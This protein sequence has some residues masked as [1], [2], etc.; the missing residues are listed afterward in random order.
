M[1]LEYHDTIVPSHKYANIGNDTAEWDD[2]WF[3][4]TVHARRFVGDELEISGSIT[5]TDL[6]A[7]NIIANVSIVGPNVT[8]GVDPGH[9]HSIYLKADGTTPLT[10]DWTTGAHSIIGSDHWYMRADDKKMFFGGS[11]EGSIFFD[12][13]ALRLENPAGVLLCQDEGTV[14]VGEVS[15]FNKLTVTSF[16]NALLGASKYALKLKMSHG[17]AGGSTPYPYVLFGIYSTTETDA[18]FGG[19]V[20]T[21][22]GQRNNV[23]HAGTGT[24][25]LALANT[26]IIRIMPTGGNITTARVLTLSAE[27][28]SSVGGVYENL[29]GLYIFPIAGATSKNYAI[30]T[31]GGLNYHRGSTGLG[32][33]PK[34]PSERLVVDGSIHLYANNNMLRLGASKDARIYY[35]GTDLVIEPDFVGS[36]AVKI[37]GD[38][39]WFGAGT[40]LPHGDIFGYEVG[41]TITFSGTGVANK[42]Q[43]DSFA[44]NGE[45]NLM[46]NDHTNDHIVVLKTGIYLVTASVSITST[47]GTAYE[48]DFACW[49]NDGATELRNVHAHRKLSGGGGDTGSKSLSGT[50]S[51]TAGDTLELWCYNV[52]N[53][54]SVVIESLTMSAVM[55]G[56]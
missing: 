44:E 43:V 14:G 3:S 17:S 50:V 38:T 56:G 23:H 10:A 21:M 39:F 35:D 55:A 32:F 16:S 46:T 31:A 45:S 53:T 22:E 42:E 27:N 7:D 29:F 37:T 18:T 1:T 24:C 15:I 8:T 6:T 19:T 51:L 20:V 40:G 4:D 54:N 33:N 2:G 41:A 25:A 9:T 30:Y 47:G 5:F 26:N 13:A 34:V 28:L 48:M 49:K 52:T 12:G 36:G 11:D